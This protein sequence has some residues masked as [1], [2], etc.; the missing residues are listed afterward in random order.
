MSINIT[1]ILLFIL[2]AL[3]TWYMWTKVRATV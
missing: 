3:T 1:A 2:L